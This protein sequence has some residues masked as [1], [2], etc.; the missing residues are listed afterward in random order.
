MQREEKITSSQ[1]K[2]K[3]QS[4]FSPMGK[5]EKKKKKKKHGKEHAVGE[6]EKTAWLKQ[7]EKNQRAHLHV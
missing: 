6:K 4:T 7:S 3:E 2:R 1:G 5:T